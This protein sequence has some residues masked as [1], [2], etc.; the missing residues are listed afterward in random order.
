MDL[1]L[2]MALPAGTLHWNQGSECAWGPQWLE[3]KCRFKPRQP[4][5]G[6]RG[7]WQAPNNCGTLGRGRPLPS[8]LGGAPESVLLKSPLETLLLWSWRSAVYM[9][10]GVTTGLTPLLSCGL[11]KRTGWIKP[12]PLKF[13]CTYFVWTSYT[14][15]STEY[16]LYKELC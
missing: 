16:K 15:I 13:S 10:P 3:A 14:V 5:S 7:P 6:Q 2:T 11:R 12:L 4:D 1:I 8:D 9:A